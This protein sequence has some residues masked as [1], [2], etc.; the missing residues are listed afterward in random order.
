MPDYRITPN[1]ENTPQNLWS[2]L[3]WSKKRSCKTV[4]ISCI[5]F[6]KLLLAKIPFVGFLLRR[7]CTYFCMLFKEKNLDLSFEFL[8]CLAAQ[9]VLFA[10]EAG[11]SLV[12]SCSTIESSYFWI[13]EVT[14]LP[15]V[16]CEFFSFSSHLLLIFPTLFLC[17]AS[18]PAVIFS[19]Y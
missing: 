4:T 16:D 13:L 19:S 10:T 14:L 15:V 6:Y 1:T 11:S 8:K 12:S 9:H 3:I 5:S 2:H 18:V 7:K 17:Q